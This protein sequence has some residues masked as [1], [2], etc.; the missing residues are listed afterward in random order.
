VPRVAERFE[1]TA[2]DGRTLEAVVE[3]P[4]DGTLVV[5]HHGTP[6]SASEF[7]PP[8]VTEAAVR[9]LRLAS[10]SRPGGAGSERRPGRNV[11]DCAADAAAVADHLEARRF[12]VVGGSGGGPHALACA[13]LLPDRVIAAATIASVAPFHAE[14]LDWS[15]GMGEEN[16]DEFAAA[17]AGPEELEAFMERWATELRKITGEQVLDSLGDLVSEPDAAVLTGEYADFAAV[18]IRDAMRSGIWGWFDDDIALLGDWGFGLGEIDVPVDLWHGDDDRF[19]PQAH[20][21]WLA[22]HVEG[23]NAHLLEGHGHL[24]LAV[25]HFGE[26]LDELVA[27]SARGRS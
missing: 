21:G 11:A 4:A 15:D 12:Y 20:G 16:L 22:D 26:I 9:G 8:H 14:G 19:V 5:S 23:A 7:W 3:G 10:Y 18:S 1:V 25:A 2:A 6:G 17:Q 27:V 24:S 13:A